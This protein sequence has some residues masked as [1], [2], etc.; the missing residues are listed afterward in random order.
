MSTVTTNLRRHLWLFVL[1]A[2]GLA[3]ATA[4]Y[5]AAKLVAQEG[6]CPTASACYRQNCE[7]ACKTMYCIS[8]S[9]PDPGPIGSYCYVCSEIY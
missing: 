2:A 6:A 9:C 1:I 4:A 7:K 8:S 3:T 5:G